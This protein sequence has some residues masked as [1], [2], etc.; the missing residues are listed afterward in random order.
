MVILDILCVSSGFVL[1]VVAGIL[2]VGVPMRPWILVCTLGLALLISLGKRRGEV[3]LLGK[4]A[5]EHRRI[6]E[7]YPLEFLDVL[8]VIAATI[9]LV[10]YSLFTFDS[11]HWAGDDAHRAVRH[12]RDSSVSLPALRHPARPIRRNSLSFVTAGFLWTRSSG[13]LP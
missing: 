4:A 2:A 12:L 13:G 10:A 3:L 8:I 11:G 7:H 5:S 9:T 6:L 1:R